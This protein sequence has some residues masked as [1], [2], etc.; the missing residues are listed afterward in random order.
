MA[1]ARCLMALRLPR[2]RDGCYDDEAAFSAMPS[3]APR[4]VAIVAFEGVQALDVT[5]PA[6]VFSGA[7][8]HHPGAYRVLIGSP[9]GG[10]VAT[11]SGVTLGRT[12]ALKKVE[13][14][15]DTVLVAGGDE[16]PL[17][18]AILEDGLAD[19]LRRIAASSRRMGSVCTGAFALGAAGLLAGRRATTHW[20][21]CE[22][23]QQLVPEARVEP[24]ALHTFD[25]G[26]CTSAGVTAGIDLS[27]A[28][29]EE[30]LGREVAAQVAR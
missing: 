30:D 9:G 13:G 21:A 24:D 6:S 18:R 10:D 3:G 26:V 5:G 19:W 1:M 14:P 23:L 11:D 27:L 15:L 25:G 16:E 29:V 8:H 20:R 7:N 2:R 12:V 17:T 22:L 4:T 28:L